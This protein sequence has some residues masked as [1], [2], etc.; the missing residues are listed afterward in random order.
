M[1]EHP[2]I[3]STEMVKAILEGR[4]TQ[5]RRTIKPQPPSDADV[6]A[7]FAPEIKEGKAPEGCWY[8]NENGL[9]FH[10]KCPYGQ[11]GDHLWVRETWT[12]GA[13]SPNK[14]ADVIYKAGDLKYHITVSWSTIID[15][16]GVDRDWGGWIPDNWRPSIFM[17]RW[18]CRITLEITGLR[19]ERLQEITEEDAEAEGESWRDGGGSWDNPEIIGAVENYAHLWDSLNAKR[20]YGWKTNPWVWVIEFGAMGVRVK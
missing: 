8:E 14:V 5:T 7:W 6:F 19:V 15:W 2:I 10:C 16:L 4:K 17:P 9:T 20:G 1:K 12:V 13:Y 18:A 11:V 3:F